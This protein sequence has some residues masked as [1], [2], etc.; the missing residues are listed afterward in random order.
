MIYRF[1]L[2]TACA[3]TLFGCSIGT[4]CWTATTNATASFISPDGSEDLTFW[5]SHSSPSGSSGSS[6][7]STPLDLE[8]TR[9]LTLVTQQDCPGNAFRLGLDGSLAS[10]G[11]VAVRSGWMNPC[12]RGESSPAFNTAAW[13]VS[14]KVIID[15]IDESSAAHA[16]IARGRFDARLTYEDGRV[17]QLVDGK[18]TIAVDAY[19]CLP[20]VTP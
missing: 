20:G 9:E 15:E 18:L 14:G 3:A 12:K 6:G 1:V 8:N 17:F 16:Q 13:Q 2:V 5:W 7:S 11:I 4:D 10:P 19:R